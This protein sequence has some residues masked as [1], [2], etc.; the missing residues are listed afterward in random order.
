M[1]GLGRPAYPSFKEG[2]WVLCLHC[3]RVFKFDGKNYD[4]VFKDCDGGAADILGWDQVRMDH[5]DF[6]EEPELGIRYPLY[7]KGNEKEGAQTNV[8]TTP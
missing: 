3:E 6:P 4:C 8:R 2:D 7:K 5:P 1:K